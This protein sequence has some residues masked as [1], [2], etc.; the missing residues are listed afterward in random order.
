M[1]AC[2]VAGPVSAE[3]PV[4]RLKEKCGVYAVELAVKNG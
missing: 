4:W 3:F 2:N 1:H